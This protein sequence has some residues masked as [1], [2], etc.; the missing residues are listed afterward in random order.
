MPPG[1]REEG[2]SAFS[3]LQ[4]CSP[5]LAVLLADPNSEQT[6]N[7]AMWVAESKCPVQKWIWS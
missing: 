7:T 5:P 2:A 3:P 1:N 4:V 6:G